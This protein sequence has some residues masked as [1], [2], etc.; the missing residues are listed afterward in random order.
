MHVRLTV[1]HG[2]VHRPRWRSVEANPVSE[3]RR[4]YDLTVS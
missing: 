4:L 1:P 3:I 2:V